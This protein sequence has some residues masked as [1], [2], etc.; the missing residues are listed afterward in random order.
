MS[1]FIQSRFEITVRCKCGFP[2]GIMTEQSRHDV[3]TL[4]IMEGLLTLAAS[5][6]TK[7]CKFSALYFTLCISH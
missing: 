2:F 4:L 6:L 1:H 7:L 3:R 5:V